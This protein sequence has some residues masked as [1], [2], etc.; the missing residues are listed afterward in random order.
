[1]NIKKP[2]NAEQKLIKETIKKIEKS[3]FNSL[4]LPNVRKVFSSTIANEIVSVQPMTLPTGITNFFNM[5][6]IAG[7]T[8]SKSDVGLWEKHLIP[9]KMYRDAST[10][11]NMMFVKLNLRYHPAIG[12]AG[13]I[14]SLKFLKG[15]KEYE[16]P[17]RYRMMAKLDT[18][19]KIRKKPESHFVRL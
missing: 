9:G 7:I 4:K 17:I 2:N 11:Y 16:I 3:I 18:T 6:Y 5:V 10:G 14:K 13:K 19:K 12:D 8:I 15:D 1:M